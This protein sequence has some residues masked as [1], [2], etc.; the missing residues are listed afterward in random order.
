MGPEALDL[1][2]Q[3]GVDTLLL[4]L[5]RLYDDGLEGAG[6]TITA[7]KARYLRPLG[8]ATG[9]QQSL[10][11][12]G[13]NIG[14]LHL[15]GQL[16]RAGKRALQG[17]EGYALAL[18]MALAG[19]WLR[20]LREKHELVIVSVNWPLGKGGAPSD[21][22]RDYA[23]QLAALGADLVIGFG[24]EAVQGV[25]RL[26]AGDREALVAYSMGTLLSENR[27]RLDLQAGMVLQ[28][29]LSLQDGRWRADSLRYSPTCVH[30]WSADRKQHFAVIP[31]TLPYPEGLTKAQQESLSRAFQHIEEAMQG[32]AAQLY[33]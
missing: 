10:R 15:T 27:R 2:R 11:V 14:W 28:I 3:A 23:R 12:N 18:D 1:I 16:S 5:G 29:A 6:A 7:L 21:A 4:P 24:G 25:E 30:K 22:Q 26:A 20:G 31:S 13:I 8:P 19:E 33:R 32:G 9:A 17:E